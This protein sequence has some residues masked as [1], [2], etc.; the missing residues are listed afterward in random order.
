MREKAGSWF[1]KVILGLIVLVFVFWGV[2]GF[3]SQRFTTVATVNGAPIS[4]EEYRQ[5]YN[6]LLERY[7]QQFGDNLDENMLNML[8]LEQQ[9][10][11]SLV[12]QSL[13]RQEAQRLDIRVTDRELVENIRQMGAFQRNGAFDRQLYNRVL[14]MNRL[15]PE[16]FEAMRR[17]S[18][19][20]GKMRAFISDAVNVSDAEA[21]E[22]Y[23]WNNAEVNLEYVRFAPEDVADVSATDEEVLA[24][25]EANTES[26]KTE[27]RV[28]ARYVAFPT[29]E[30][31]DR[32]TLGDEEI[33][34]YYEAHPDEF[35]EPKTVQ[36]RH[37]LFSLEEG[38]D[39]GVVDEKRKKAEEV[40][41]QARE[42]ADFAE[43]ARA[44]SEGP[45]AE[46]GGDLGTFT[47]ER[48]VAPFSEAAF[49][50]SAGEISDPVRTRFGWHVI[51]VE[52]V[53]EAATTSLE[54]ARDDIVETLKAESAKEL[55]FDAAETFVGQIYEGDALE[56]VA[57]TQGMA[58]Q[59]TEFFTRAQG[60]AGM[61]NAAAFASAAFSL[62][63]GEI[64]EA[65]ELPD[66]YY[67]IQVIGKEPAEIAPFAEV[68]ERARADLLR[69]RREEKA[70]EAAQAFLTRL[71]EGGLE[72]AETESGAPG[73]SAASGETSAA[74]DSDAD[75]ETPAGGGN[76]DGEAPAAD[77]ETGA[78]AF[79]ETGFFAREEPIPGIGREREIA[80]AAF[81]LTAEEPLPE[82]PLKGRTGYYVVRLKERKR[83][84]MEAFEAE[85]SDIKSN[86][87]RR[88]QAGAF[89]SWLAQV[90][91]RS[92]VVVEE[93]ALN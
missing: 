37:I 49:S 87:S 45:S 82:A 64:S 62:E 77:S 32:V 90:K 15:T 73:E 68:A 35:N 18:L 67:V 33:V 21:R 41:V 38:A 25:Y 47:R 54:E 8:N 5:A 19:L 44:H 66:G 17:D 72:A 11:D 92:E 14:G 71:K 83:P 27:P 46:R 89:E 58:P 60:P 86:L 4:M 63:E 51:K 76:S 30:F 3:Q 91:S 55:A 7:R 10:L 69:R 24:H 53:N 70:R 79:E 22:W 59:E 43:L 2:G 85:K 56:A 39:P 78:S 9:A 29:A 42:G 23:D 93:G 28:K 57:E 34:E 88:K 81:Q 74:G 1:I 48:M 50:M 20:V 80:R 36:A 40:A 13:I 52:A 75:Q 16:S 84:D 65:R 31:Q 61:A 6:G 12:D 26:Y